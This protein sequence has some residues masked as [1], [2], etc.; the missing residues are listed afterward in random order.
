[1]LPKTE[2]TALCVIV[3]TTAFFFG[4]TIQHLYHKHH[5]Q[6]Q[7]VKQVAFKGTSNAHRRLYR[8]DRI[9]L[10]PE[11][12]YCLAKNIYHEAGIE[13]HHG[14]LAVAQITLNRIKKGIWGNSFCQVVYSYAQFSWTLFQDK[15]EEIPSG[16]LWNASVRAA[17][18]FLAGTRLIAL[19]NSLHYHAVYV[20]PDWSRSMQAIS[21]IGNHVFYMG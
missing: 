9:T 18:S 12:F 3:F 10:P 15:R 17:R 20:K 16:A 2:K 5:K 6:P 1:M 8:T 19:D 14:K 11:E 7:P 4:H 13:S 21:V